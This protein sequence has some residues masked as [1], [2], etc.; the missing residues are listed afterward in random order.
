[1]QRPKRVVIGRRLGA[2]R[3]ST[4]A[5]AQPIA[6]KMIYILLPVHN[7]RQI[8][9]SFIRN[10]AAQT[11]TDFH[12]VLIDDGST[13]GTSE[14]VLSILP[15]ATILKGDGS[16]WWGGSL[17]RGVRWLRR[18]KVP[19]DALILFINDDVTVAPDY[20]ERAISVMRER[21]R[22]FV[23]SRLRVSGERKPTETGTVVD[24]KRLHFSVSGDPKKINCLATQ[25]L[26]A[27]WRSVREVGGFHPKLLPHY[28]SDYE[29][30]MRAHRKGFVCETSPD[31][32]IDL[33][34]ESTGFHEIENR[35]FLPFLRKF[36]SLKSPANPIYF[37]TFACMVLPATSV[38]PVVLRIWRDAMRTMVRAFLTS[39]RT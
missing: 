10:L 34:R 23:L 22:S 24:L 26:F 35:S 6:M 20:L 21:P 33:N 4:C 1:M 27:W 12:L 36:F 30:T 9:E 16:W 38:V 15:K 11:C 18:A 31:L 5:R 19:E 25:G 28:L 8:T 14:M 3:A 32:L 37:T 29:Y 13:D 39:V 2:V 7:R 17:D